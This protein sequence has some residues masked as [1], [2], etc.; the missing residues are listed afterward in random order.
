VHSI[1]RRPVARQQD[2]PNN[3]QNAQYRHQLRHLLFLKKR[4]AL[5]DLHDRLIVVS[6]FL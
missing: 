5:H 6:I 4:T 2:E 1:I 3:Q